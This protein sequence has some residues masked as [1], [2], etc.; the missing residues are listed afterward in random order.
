MTVRLLHTS[1]VHLGQYNAARDDD[2]RQRQ[3]RQHRAFTR[4][5][6]L[7]IDEGVDMLLI[8]GDFFDN[9]RAGSDVIDFTIEQLSRLPVP[10]IILPGNHDHI[11]PGSIYERVDFERETDRVRVIATNEGHWLRY[12]SLDLAVWGRADHGRLRPNRPLE[13]APGRGGERWQIAIGHGHYVPHGERSDR[14]YLIY[15]EEIEVSQ[16]DYVAL[17]HWDHFLP[18]RH[19]E[20]TACYSGSPEPPVQH[21]AS[22]S[23][24]VALVTL[25]DVTGVHVEPRAVGD[26][27][28]RVD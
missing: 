9:A 27:A 25:D 22:L 7:A 18:I 15:A 13:D 21:T 20:V 23:G 10:A 16:R 8:A 26:G 2:Q 11:G 5:I 1:D 17:G 24:V 3:E 6:D 4:V 12:E 28:G 19:G 14:S